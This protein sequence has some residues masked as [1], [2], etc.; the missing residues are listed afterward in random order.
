MH[1]NFLVPLSIAAI[2]TSSS[3]SIAS[4]ATEPAPTQDV[5][6][7]ALGT[8]V[9]ETL[10]TNSATMS[11]SK[12][13][14]VSPTKVKISA[15]AKFE[16]PLN[17]AKLDGVQLE[18]LVTFDIAK[19]PSGQVRLSNIKGFKIHSVEKQLWANLFDLVVQPLQNAEGKYQATLTAGKAGIKKV[20]D[21]QLPQKVVD[22]I[23]AIVQQAVAFEQQLANQ[24]AGG[25]AKKDEP[26]AVT[27]ASTPEPTAAAT[28]ASPQD[29]GAAVPDGVGLPPAAAGAVP[30][31]VPGATEG[32]PGEGAGGGSPGYAG[33]D[34]GNQETPPSSPTTPPGIE[35]SPD[36]APGPRSEFQPDLKPLPP[37]PIMVPAA[38]PSAPAA[39]VPS[40]CTV[41]NRVSQRTQALGQRYDIDEESEK[42]DHLIFNLVG[43]TFRAI[44][45][46]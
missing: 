13:N 5:Q 9:A 15:P 8:G 42:D 40:D 36:P 22:S 23:N 24:I 29:P 7:D 4:A 31:G 41:P 11:L 35:P 6:I 21:A 46:D 39:V 26:A 33:D 10:R 30:D 45:R 3:I 14:D 18:K 19:D 43:K 27:P 37:A 38:R 20:V 1:R 16:K 34:S 17:N 25:G 2:V 28:S 12:K 44:L 32:S